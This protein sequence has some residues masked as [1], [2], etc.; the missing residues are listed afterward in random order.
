MSR[1]IGKYNLITLNDLNTFINSGII[2]LN[3][4][5]K[6]GTKIN[7]KSKFLYFIS[8]L[9]QKLYLEE[10]D[11]IIPFFAEKKIY[12]PKIIINGF[13]ENRLNNEENKMVLSLINKIF[14][15]I[16]TKEYFYYIYKKFSKIFRR[17]NFLQKEETLISNFF[18]I[19]D[20]W[21]LFY[22]FYDDSKLQEKYFSLYGNNCINISIPNISKNYLYTEITINLIKSP[23]FPLLNKSKNNFSFIK[24]YKFEKNGSKNEICN[25]KYNDIIKANNE[26]DKKFQ[27]NINRIK[28]TINETKIISEINENN[29]KNE[30]IND[31][32][33]INKFN[34]MK[35]LN[36]FNGKIESIEILR[37]YK[38]EKKEIIS[39]IDVKPSYEKLKIN[40]NYYIKEKKENKYEILNEKYEEKIDIILKNNNNKNVFYKYYPEFLYNEIKYYGGL[41][42]FIPL[43][44]IFH[45][46]L[47]KVDNNK[48]EINN[49]DYS[50][51]IKDSLKS[52]FKI[53]VNIIYC[54]KK[55]LLNFFEIIIPFISAFSEVNETLNAQL[56]KEIYKDSYFINL[57]ILIMISPSPNS[58]KRLFQ[59]LIGLNE[60]S[61]INFIFTDFKN[62]EKILMRYNSLEWYSFMLFVYIEFI[63]LTTN[64]IDKVPKS[65]FSLLLNIFNSLSN[66]INI[67]KKLDYLIKTKIMLMIKTFLGIFQNFYPK[68]VEIPEGFKNISENDI[69]NLL[70]NLVDYKDF[71]LSL[72][73]YMMKIYFSLTNMNLISFEN[74]GKDKNE[75]CS[76]TKYYTL[77]LSLKD[78]LVIKEDDS[79]ELKKDK[80]NLKN[81]FKE[82]LL[83]FPE[84][85]SIILEILNEPKEIN[86]VKKEE[87]IMNELVDYHK[88]YHRLMKELFIFNRPW[89]DHKLFFSLKKNKLKYKNINYYT[90]N[91]QR[92]IIYPILDYQKQ[93]PKFS[94]FKIDKNFYL[95]EENKK[96]IENIYD[97]EYNFDI[98]SAELNKLNNKINEEL[99]TKIKKDFRQNIQ[100][101][102]VCLIKQT[103]H[104]KGRL[105]TVMVNGI[106]DRI[107]F[108]SYTKKE[109]K[110]LPSCNS[111]ESN[112]QKYELKNNDQNTHLCYGSFFQC[113]MKDSNMKIC[114]KINDIRLIMRRI[115]FYRKSGIEFF[116]KTKSYFFNF[117]ENPLLNGN[118][119]GMSEQNCDIFINLLVYYTQDRFFSI[120]INNKIIGYTNIFLNLFNKKNNGEDLIFIKNKYINELI[121][122]WIKSDKKNNVEKG[123]SSFDVIILLNLLS[124][125][126]YNDLYQ[127]PVFPILFFY[128]KDIENENN[129]DYKLVERDLGNHIGFQICTKMGEK[130]KKKIM[131]FFET[132]K[133][134]IENGLVQN[135]NAYFFESNFSNEKYVCNF[136]LRVFPYSF[137][138]IELQGDGYED[139]KKLFDS[140]EDTFYNISANENDL[141]ELIPEFFY[142]PEIFLNINKLNFNKKNNNK[143]INDVKIPIEILSSNFDDNNL[144]NGNS[145]EK[146]SIFYFYCKFIEKMK[147]NLENR[148]LDVYKWSNL[149]FGKNQKYYN[150]DKKDLLF[151]SETYIDFSKEKKVDLKNNLENDEI[152]NSVEFGLLPIQTIFTEVELKQMQISQNKNNI[153]NYIKS[154]II[155][156]KEKIFTINSNT[157]NNNE[158]KPKE[159]ISLNIN[160]YNY[161]LNIKFH[162]NISKIDVFN[163]N[164]LENEFYENIDSI[165]FFDYNKRLNMFIISS[166]DG[167]LCIYILPGKL[168]NVIKHPI[169]NHHFD[170]AFLSSNPFPSVIAFD[171]SNNIFYSYSINGNFIHQKEIFHLINLKDDNNNNV[172]VC[173]ILD[174]ENGIY[175]DFFLI[176]INNKLNIDFNGAKWDNSNF[177]INA[178]FFEKIEYI[179]I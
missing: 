54:S 72:F 50:N 127:Y 58:S 10:D 14:P 13:I 169:N 87:K 173:P 2:Q 61:K 171:K 82:L 31:E 161:K 170:Y 89:S 34:K 153:L 113:P 129:D 39:K 147:N 103:H 51:R 108:Y 16:M 107:Y 59:N 104:I 74:S 25:I 155:I 93:Y 85:K 123:L 7:D 94:Y 126:S 73:G 165:I 112:K 37:V 70:N 56:K 68:K 43:L 95:E 66:N 11:Y 154:Q 90:N 132:T 88:Q 33:S 100:I 69:P 91:F 139:P 179:D 12:I 45:K 150:N 46:L 151:K 172:H 120:N 178:P 157:P 5:N 110:E 135:G 77:F 40:F 63:I 62:S 97:E 9:K 117:T 111:I 159:I 60:K 125:R 18:N 47:T 53:M 138:A 136:L 3:S 101:Y 137:I 79:Q 160:D 158:I 27:N 148:F 145:I 177:L 142:F 23:L 102:N 44:K 48:N 105:F 81:N 106:I 42:S 84:H 80:I 131:K 115:Y 144:C 166:N 149:I 92:P 36:H 99:I 65:I 162:I 118:F 30:I 26:K 1:I 24:L 116:T 140:I 52:F 114:I 128:D 78:V 28:L 41:E 124:N 35:I 176:Q 6:K 75:E 38:K 76:Y 122:S 19:F 20:I 121:N 22:S 64:D 86:F 168:I 156:N 32:S 49:T 17:M 4:I 98:K 163:N 164:K 134:E 8:I 15:F 96:E 55:N 119:K 143:I 146:K 133:D 109:N 174:G 83:E 167:Y 130:R 152:M 175:K 21:K 67:V 141:R 57:Y 29:N 71:F